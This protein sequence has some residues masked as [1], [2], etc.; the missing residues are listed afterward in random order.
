MQNH[1]S[2]TA[3]MTL[4]EMMIV[5][6]I[7]AIL[8]SLA[9]PSLRTLLD[10]QKVS[11]SARAF[12]S[13]V[14]LARSEAVKRGERVDLVPAFRHE[15]ESGWLVLLDANNN[16]QADAGE[17]VLHRSAEQPGNLHI[18][19]SLRDAKKTYLAFDPSGRPRSAS[20]SALP[21]FGSLLF[22]VGTQKRKI[23]IG[24]LGR[25][26]SCDPDRDGAAC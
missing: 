22:S 20:S 13:A 3:G 4:V 19:A 24:F 21:Q 11:T 16:Q 12:Q 8:S 14:M 26:R 10:R 2:A 9:L 25:L 5:L 1:K 18:V 17:T 15:W 7:V 23:I 6:T